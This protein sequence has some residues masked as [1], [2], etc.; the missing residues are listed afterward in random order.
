ML[1]TAT[2][3]PHRWP[4]LP[5]DAHVPLLDTALAAPWNTVSSSPKFCLS[6]S[7]GES[8]TTPPL[9]RLPHSCRYNNLWPV[10]I[11]SNAELSKGRQM[12]VKTIMTSGGP[13]QT[14]RQHHIDS[15]P[16]QK[17]VCILCN[18]LQDAGPI[19]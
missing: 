5:A 8:S 14:V 18:K 1:H 3:I 4:I 10:I 19:T 15:E 16:L 2:S 7:T 13:Q 11:L 6:V 12:N 17:A 9:F